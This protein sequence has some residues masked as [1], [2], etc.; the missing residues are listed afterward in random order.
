MKDREQAE[1][2]VREEVFKMDSV[3][4]LRDIKKSFY[5]GKPNELEILHGISLSC[6]KENL[7][8]SS[9]LPVP[10]NQPL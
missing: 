6:K 4:K 7:C 9:G 1:V 10:E 2:L 3:I 8:R 5:I